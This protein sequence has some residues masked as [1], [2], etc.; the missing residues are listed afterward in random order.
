M[1]CTPIS[2]ARR[3][4]AAQWRL[5]CA[6]LA[7]A[8]LVG[9]PA[10]AQQ[11]VNAVPVDAPIVPGERMSDWLLRTQGPDAD[12]TALHWRADTERGPQQ[13]LRAAVHDSLGAAHPLA[14]L[15]A[16]L[17]VTG[18]LTL[19]RADARWLQIAPQDDPVLA[20]GQTVRVL[21]RPTAVGVL[22]ANGGLCLLPHRP[23]ALAQ[24]YIA[25]CQGTGHGVDRA[26]L[27]QPD[28][29]VQHVGVAA[30]SAA[31]QPEP[32]TGAWVWAPATAAQLSDATSS[33]LAR[34][35]ATQL[36]PEALQPELGNALQRMDW[37]APVAYRAPPR[38]LPL[39]ANN[40]GEIGLLQ[41]PSARMEAPG[42]ARLTL[43]TGSPYARVNVGL[44]PLDWMEVGFRYTDIAYAL[45]GPNI[46]G[47]QTYKDKSIDVKLRLVEEGGGMP[48]L[49]LGLRDIG[50]TGL[51]SSEY[52]VASKRWGNW[53]ASAGLAWGYLGAR[54]NLR[55]PLGFLGEA[56]KTRGTEDVGQGGTI[57]TGGMFHGDAGLLGGVQWHSPINGLVLKA[58]LDGNDYRHEPFGAD[59]QAKSPFNWGAVYRYSPG[60]DLSAAWERGDRLAFTLTLHTELDKF[61]ALKQ[62]DKPLPPIAPLPAVQS[63]AAAPA[64][65]ATPQPAPAWAETASVLASYTGWQVLEMDQ[66]FSTLTVR[67]ESDGAQFVG[68]RIDTAIQVLHAKLP[69][70]VRHLVLEL[71]ERGVALSTTR[72]DRAEWVAQHTQ[73]QPPSLLLPSRQTFPGNSAVAAER[74]APVFQKPL[75]TGFSTVWGPSYRQSFGGPD[76]FLLYELGVQATVEKR[77]SPGTWLTATGNARL[78]DDYDNFKY[79][80]PSNLP[81]VRTYVREYVTTERLT[82]PQLQLTH[83]QDMGAGHYASVYGGMLEMMYG[84]VGGEWLYR[85]WLSP[86]AV[87]VDV[88]HVRQRDFAQDLR[89]RDYEVNT[90]HATLYWDTGWNDVQLRLSAGQY[91]AGDTGMTAEVRRTFRNGTAIGMWAS[92]TNVSAEQFGEG[93]FDKGIYISIPFDAMMP[94]SMPGTANLVWHPLLRDGGA[95]LSRSFSLFDLTSQRDGR[96][97]RLSSRPVSDANR[98]RS[99]EDLSGIEDEPGPGL[100]R[101]GGAA[102][103]GIG[104]GLANVP[105]RAWAWGAGAVLGASL[106]DTEV[107]NWAKDHQGGNW[108]HLGNMA[109]NI[110]YAMA[111]GSGLL[112]TGIAGDDAASAARASLTAAAFT[113]GGNALTKLAVG[114]ARPSDELGNGS[115]N[116]F[117][118]SAAQSS[119]TS[120]HVALAFALVTP[121]AQQYDNPWWYALAGTTALGRIQNRE[122][123]LSDTVAGGLMGYAIGSL[124]YEQQ[125]GRRRSLRLSATT[126][127]VNASWSF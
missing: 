45:Y 90:G 46:A 81:R 32:A 29:R 54:G 53:D 57:S 103:Q 108:E 74:D 51:F 95:M 33:N 106:L 83:V 110:P 111:L 125:M 24:D 68:E 48:Q 121:F 109:N 65:P 115:F 34:F 2:V 25:A 58:E 26:W 3:R 49:A 12:L 40:W 124:S 86:L 84:G 100:W 38:D 126:Q 72:V 82:L 10:Q 14:A 6:L 98:L 11:A 87:G 118:S 120:N 35:L 114:R 42:A 22:S 89:F 15:V 66:Q 116:G 102:A 77:F 61:E 112:F 27:A 44:Q 93:S 79:D 23:G 94:K 17:P 5:L 36:P 20:P 62:L 88:N 73:A 18:R 56:Y 75:D 52:L 85:P 64:A 122:H 63:F 30:W 96:N 80:A 60:I 21:P 69:P 107:D 39:L 55:A 43:A 50:G 4:R 91:L 104:H 8:C 78:L 1:S 59:L 127:S 31:D 113:M 117:T 119:F 37:P 70:G 71:Q 13:R 47:D 97:W 99:A 16:R 41:T 67:A 7:L 28:G 101:S 19:A 76:G 123:W 92:K 105:G 9:T